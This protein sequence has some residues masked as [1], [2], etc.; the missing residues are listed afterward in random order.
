MPG[1]SQELSDLDIEILMAVVERKTRA[2]YVNNLV[3]YFNPR[4]SP[5]EIKRRRNGPIRQWLD[6]TWSDYWELLPEI[7]FDA[8]QAVITTVGP[9]LSQVRSYPLGFASLLNDIAHHREAKKTSDAT[10]DRCPS[11][12]ASLLED[13]L[14]RLGAEKTGDATGDRGGFRC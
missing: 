1:K 12:F 8:V 6:T 10:G 4:I 9:P 3:S 14:H 5:G 11:S 7:D 13:F 2:F